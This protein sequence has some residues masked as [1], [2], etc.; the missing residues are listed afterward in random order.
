MGYYD[1]H[2]KFAF[3]AALCVVSL[4]Q[5]VRAVLS[6]S[7]QVLCTIVRVTHQW[8]RKR[9]MVKKGGILVTG[10]GDFGHP[11]KNFGHV[12]LNNRQESS[13]EIWRVEG[14]LH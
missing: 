9:G 12:Y 14:A 8:K 11:Y 5:L 6:L 4:C 2:Q 10:S 13:H 7:T 3:S 1:F